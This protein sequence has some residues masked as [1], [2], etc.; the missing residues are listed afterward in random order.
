MVVFGLALQADAGVATPSDH[1]VY[2]FDQPRELTL[3]PARVAVIGAGT[4]SLVG[5]DV[6]LPGAR[7][8]AVGFADV[9]L[10]EPTR[11][12]QRGIDLIDR[13]TAKRTSE[14]KYVA[15]VY[16]G[17]DGGPVIPTPT[18]LV[19]FAP[20]ADP[21][22]RDSLVAGAGRVA[23]RDWDDMP[24]AYRIETGL[25]DGRDVMRLAAQLAQ[26]DDVIFA[27]PDMICTGGSSLI[28]NDPNFFSA[29]GL[30]N[31]GQNIGG[32]G[33]SDVD[34]NGPAAWDTELGDPNILTLV[35]D[36]GVQT[37]HPDINQTAGADFTSDA[38]P[39]GG[40]FN[41]CDNHGTAVAG[42]ISGIINNNKGACG[43]APGTR[44]VSARTFISN[45]PC[46]GNWT[47]VVSATVDALAY[48][49]SLGCR[50]SNNSNFYG[51]S[52]SAIANKYASTRANGM[53]HFASAGNFS[54]PA[55]TY[56]SS[57][58]TV[59]A[60]SAVTNRGLLAA[61]S[62]TGAIAF[63]GPGLDVYTTDRTGTNGFGGG[64]YEILDGTSFASPLC[65]GV[66]ALILSYNPS[67]TPDEVES[68]MQTTAKDL[69]ATGYDTSFGY[70]M[71]DAAA[72]LAAAGTFCLVD[73]NGDGMLNLDD[74][75]MFAAAFI[76]GS[77]V[78]DLDGNG[79]LNLDD[80]SVFA[81]GYLA[82]C[83]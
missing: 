5:E 6:G 37:D 9:E 32:I 2:F 34:M 79:T 62:N 22:T 76:A 46:D 14:A 50:V 48:G 35:I 78:A 60:I 13:A 38:N 24:G 75:N 39:A 52:S 55:P 36:V 43:I 54:D 7:V 74:I 58:P 17:D 51:F 21:A 1:V 49:E 28:P 82:G 80:I 40:P 10:V 77:L 61:F 4:R 67:L 72:A 27:E 19:R 71:P 57:L 20:N 65:A 29:W 81:A 68:I 15:P 33:V 30:H 47:T 59:N 69:G 64:N 63:G 53:V 73:I 18:I 26:R 8:R 3:D 23:E 70:G 11:A 56:P 25:R 66:A 12:R 83:P 44:V 41:S 45:V 31:I 42:C 16:I